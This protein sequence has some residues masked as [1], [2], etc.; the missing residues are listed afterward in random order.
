MPIFVD[1]QCAAYKSTMVLEVHRTPDTIYCIQEGLENTHCCHRLKYFAGR[2]LSCSGRPLLRYMR[3]LPLFTLVSSLLR[4]LGGFCCQTVRIYSTY[5]PYV[6]I[7]GRKR[8]GMRKRERGGAEG[9]VK[10]THGLILAYYAPLSCIK[11]A[12]ENI[13]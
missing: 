6:G 11:Y 1:I 7:L 5:L 4:T 8:L 2:H 12:T 3:Q 9:L 10:S 13:N